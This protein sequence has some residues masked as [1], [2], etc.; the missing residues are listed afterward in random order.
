M[1]SLVA[2]LALT[3][4][5]TFPVLALARPVTLTT[6]LN[7]YGG[8][9]AYLA[10]YVTDAAG[11]YKGTLWVAGSRSKYYR[12]LGGW[13]RESGGNL[14][15]IDGISGASVGSG[16]S[17]KISLDLADTLFDA[18]YKI[19]V[20][21]AVEDMRDSPSDVVVPLTSSGAGKPVAGRRYISAFTYDM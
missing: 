6:T 10:L 12:H 2:A 21:A 18:G 15:E 5:L 8:N 11:A 4:A 16:R 13:L 7:D 19:H 9:G 14:S 1:K 17:L 20:D 3:T